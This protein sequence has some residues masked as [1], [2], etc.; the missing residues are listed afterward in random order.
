MSTPVEHVHHGN[1]QG[2]GER[3]SD[4]TEKRKPRIFRPGFCA[5]ER[6]PKKSVRAQLRLVRGA[7]QRKKEPVYLAL[8]RHEHTLE[9]VVNDRVDVLDRLENPFPQIHV[10]V[11]ISQF[12]CLVH[13]GGRPARHGSPAERRFGVHIDLNSRIAPRIENLTGRNIGNYRHDTVLLC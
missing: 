2:V 9:R 4:V 8:F 6:N 3:A 7:V 5:G 13:A 10:G 1:R 11:S 12:D